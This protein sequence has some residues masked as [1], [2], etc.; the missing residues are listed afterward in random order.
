M[1]NKYVKRSFVKLVNKILCGY[2]NTRTCTIALLPSIL[3][4]TFSVLSQKQKNSMSF[5]LNG[6]IVIV[7]SL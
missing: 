6:D 2:F 3:D 1:K 7:L 4:I 5:G